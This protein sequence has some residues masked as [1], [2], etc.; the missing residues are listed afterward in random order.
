[1]SC[2]QQ[3]VGYPFG[4]SICIQQPIYL[5]RSMGPGTIRISLICILSSPSCDRP[6]I[7]RGDEKQ[8]ANLPHNSSESLWQRESIP[9]KTHSFEDIF[10]KYYFWN[11]L[12]DR[13]EQAR[14]IVGQ[15]AERLVCILSSQN[16]VQ[17][18]WRYNQIERLESVVH[19][20]CQTSDFRLEQY[21]AAHQSNTNQTWIR[22]DSWNWMNFNRQNR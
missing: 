5:N 10:G 20:N 6:S 1:M 11:S 14:R 19:F 12:H 13:L 7:K 17:N 22:H 3:A 9:K 8:E 16:P 15:R 2:W 21:C 4:Y 18:R